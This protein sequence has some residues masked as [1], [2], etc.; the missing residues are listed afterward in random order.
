MTLK[1]LRIL[2]SRYGLAE[3]LDGSEKLGRY[4]V[5]GSFPEERYLGCFDCEAL[6]HANPGDV[7]ARVAEWSLKAAFEVC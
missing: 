6:E 2:C 1:D 4:Y 7:E 5:F 3:P